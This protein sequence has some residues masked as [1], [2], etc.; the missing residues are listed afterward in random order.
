MFGVEA[1]AGATWPVDG[2]RSGEP[3]Q[4]DDAEALLAE[5]DAAHAE[6]G[7]AELRLLRAIR[8]LDEAG[9]WLCEGARD[10]S[11]LVSMRYGISCWKAR[12]WIGA[13]HALEALP[14]IA[15]A[16]ERGELSL[17]EVCELA[18]FA[19]P[20]DEA[21][22]VAWA[23]RVSVATI[24]HR[25]DLEVRRTAEQVLEPERCRYLDTWYTEDG[26]F[27]MQAELPAA[28]GRVVELAIER[29]TE[30][31]PP[32]PDEAGEEGSRARRADALVALCSAGLGADPD[33]DRA[34]VVVHATVEALGGRA[35]AEVES[36]PVIGTPTLERLACSARLQIVTEDE[37]GTVVELTPA[38]R[39]PPAWMVRQVRYR[40]RGCTFPGCGTRRSPRLITSG[41]GPAAGGP[42]SPTSR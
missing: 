15:R 4:G 33:P 6:V 19:T 31:I 5:A 26:R 34:T 37:A 2:G 13:A 41:S 8:G 3:A 14:R 17:D 30:R 28:Q 24:R 25:G 42:S 20:A 40:D 32:M 36:G 1:T 23:A 18:R 9:A 11:H 7:A 22:L 29:L 10:T 39:V 35:N 16:L 38:R 12:R 21:G 27:G